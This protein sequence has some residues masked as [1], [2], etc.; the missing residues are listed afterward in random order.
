[1]LTTSPLPPN[2]HLKVK[3]NG[4]AMKGRTRFAKSGLD[5]LEF[6]AEKLGARVVEEPLRRIMGEV[7]IKGMIMKGFKN[8]PLKKARESG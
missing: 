1:M 6:V 2:A 3:E 5:D 4:K 7:Y 8:W